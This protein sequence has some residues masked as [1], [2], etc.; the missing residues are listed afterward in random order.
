MGRALFT[1]VREEWE[2]PRELYAALHAEFDFTLDPCP[3]WEDG[4]ERIDGLIRPWTGERVYCNPPYGR[5][6]GLWLARAR[7]AQLAV[8]LLPARTDTVWFHEYAMKADEIRFLRGRLTFGGSK[9]NAPFP[10][11]VLIY[12]TEHT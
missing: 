3:I 12:R 10:S 8:Y 1:S 6:I 5:E 2:T 4:I 11:C 9:F 7:E